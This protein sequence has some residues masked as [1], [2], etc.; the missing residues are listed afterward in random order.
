MINY[1]R[2]PGLSE[3]SHEE[4]L[5]KLQKVSARVSWLATET[6][7]YIELNQ[8]YQLSSQDEKTLLWI[9]T[10]PFDEMNISKSSFLDDK[11]AR[12]PGRQY[13]ALEIGPRLNFS[14]AWSTNAVSICHSVGLL[15]VKRIEE[16][17]RYLVGVD[18]GGDS[19]VLVDYNT[20]L[21]ESLASVL[22]D[23]MTQC[24]YKQ[25][26]ES[27]DVDVKPDQWF[28]VDVLSEGRSALEKVNKDLG[29]A[30]DDWDLDYYTKLFSNHLKRN[31]TSVECFD[32]AQSNSEHSRHWFFRGKMIIDGEKIQDSLMEMVKKTS[33]LSN[34]NSVIRLADNSRYVFLC[35]FLHVSPIPFIFTDI[36]VKRHSQ[37]CAKT[38][39][40]SLGIL[41][42]FSRDC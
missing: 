18:C 28:E 37:H 16:S 15:Q 30:F 2:F 41:V 20:E 8:G 4:S 25:P 27:F 6:C 40:F 33:K 13:I 22:H 36:L 24:T 35:I 26:L 11:S 21:S 17:L 31:P 32:L 34:D 38:C 12:E 42:S 23:K 29:L 39:G 14:T 19:A 3:C 1:Y 5:L 9:L 10:L 7:F